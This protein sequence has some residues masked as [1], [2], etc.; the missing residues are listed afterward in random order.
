MVDLSIVFFVTVYQTLYIWHYGTVIIA[1][2]NGTVIMVLS[3][4]YIHMGLSEH[5]VCLHPMVNDQF[6]Y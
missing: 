6:P 3:K 5:V 4:Y 2:V 1:M